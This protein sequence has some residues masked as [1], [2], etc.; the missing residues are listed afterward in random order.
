M[1]SILRAPRPIGAN[2]LVSNPDQFT[3][4]RRTSRPPA[5]TS[6]APSAR[7][8]PEPNGRGVGVGA[9]VDVGSGLGVGRGGVTVGGGAGAG[10]HVG[11]RAQSAANILATSA[12]IR[13]RK[14]TLRAA[15]APP[16]VAR[17]GGRRERVGP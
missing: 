11:G 9:G 7:S 13:R 6:R 5:S 1:S 17:T 3:P 16:C 8:G 10:V 2:A 15:A 14:R 12:M 4:V